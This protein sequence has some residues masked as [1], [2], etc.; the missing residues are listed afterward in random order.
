VAEEVALN[1]GGDLW[2]ERRREGAEAGRSLAAD[3]VKKSFYFERK[4]K[5]KNYVS[6]L[7]L[8]K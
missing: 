5:K 7:F 3:R 1:Y 8:R 6:F 4:V 2:P